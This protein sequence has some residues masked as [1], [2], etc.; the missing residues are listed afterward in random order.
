V[1]ATAHLLAQLHTVGAGRSRAAAGTL[2][3]WIEWA[4][5]RGSHAYQRAE[6]CLS[7]HPGYRLAELVRELAGS[8]M[9]PM[10]ARRRATA[11]PGPR[12]LT[13]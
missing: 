1:D 5:G 2:H 11:W 4:R 6:A 10:W 3:A 8:G 7:E 9:L 13:A 12:H